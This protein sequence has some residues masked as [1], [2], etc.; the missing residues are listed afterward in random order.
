MDKIRIGIIG[1][2]QIGKVHLDACKQI[3]DVEVVA[4]CGRTMENLEYCA[5]NWNIP[6]V[7]QDYR[8]LLKRDDIDAVDVCLHNNLHA[9]VTIAAF[10][11]GKHVYC[12]KPI[13]GS[14]ADGA[15]MLEAAK[16][17]GKKLF[18][19]LTFIHKTEVRAAKRLIDGNALGEIYHARSKGFRRRNRPYVDGY[20]TADFVKKELSGGGAIYDM[21]VYHIGELLFL[22]GLPKP[23]RMSGKLYQKTGM[24]EERRALS[25]FDVD[26]LAVGFIHFENGV[27]M[28]IFESW[29]V[30]LDKFDSSCILGSKGGVKL[31][32]FSFHTTL[33]DLELDCTG[34]LDKMDERWHSTIKN[35]YAFSSWKSHGSNLLVAPETHWVAALRG[36]VELLPTAQVTLDTMLIQEGICLSDALGREVTAEEVISASK[37]TAVNI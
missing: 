19:Q 21:A 9:P 2:G 29:A 20:G 33:C 5:K 16:R 22:M 35:E 26:E 13:A 32:P 12:E 23:L 3:P 27:T 18:I 15:A 8:E 7:Y 37:S 34:D 10:E 31:D 17:F 30:H 36:E 24:D 28:D 6:H 4:I 1:V 25:G 14:Y 11:A